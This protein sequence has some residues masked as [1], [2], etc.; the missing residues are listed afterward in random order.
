MVQIH[1]PI[2][3][4]YVISFIND[5]NI[6]IDFP[7]HIIRFGANKHSFLQK[8]RKP[9]EVK[10]SQAARSDAECQSLELIPEHCEFDQLNSLLHG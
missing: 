7:F 4:F 1:E 6:I 3:F 9:I 5:F 8:K 10:S 2:S